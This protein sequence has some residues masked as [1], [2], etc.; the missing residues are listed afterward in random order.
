M[1]GGFTFRECAVSGGRARQRREFVCYSLHRRREDGMVNHRNETMNEAG[2][3]GLTQ[4][5]CHGKRFAIV[6]LVSLVLASITG[7]RR[8]SGVTRIGFGAVE[9]DRKH[10]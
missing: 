4:V 10:Q 9:A 1:G 2:D 7:A 3:R 8:G 5:A 6:T